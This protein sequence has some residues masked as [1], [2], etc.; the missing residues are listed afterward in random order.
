MEYATRN[1]YHEY[2][3]R[4]ASY[5]NVMIDMCCICFDCSTL[6]RIERCIP[7]RCCIDGTER[8]SF[9]NSS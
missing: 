5:A 6:S 9:E 7:K 8:I 3:A 2:S 4:K 1:Q